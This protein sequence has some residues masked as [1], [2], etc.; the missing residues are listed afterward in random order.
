M[1]SIEWNGAWTEP[2]MRPSSHSRRSRT[3]GTWTPGSAASRAGW[4]TAASRPARRP[5]ASSRPMTRSA[6]PARRPRPGW[7]RIPTVG[8]QR[9][10][11]ALEAPVEGTSALDR[12]VGAGDVPHEA[13][14]SPVR[15]AQGS[16]RR[17]VSTRAK[18]VG[19]G[20]WPGVW[21]A[22]TRR[23]PSA[24]SQPSS[25][26][27]WGYSAPAARCRWSAAPVASASRPWPETWSAR[28]PA[29][30]RARKRSRPAGRDRRRS[31]EGRRAAPAGRTRRSRRTAARAS[32][33]GSERR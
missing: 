11:A 25:K 31:P 23:R 21:I 29:Y 9:Q 7:S 22:R 2:G 4:S 30:F 33:G 18:A 24:S 8:R 32:R 10:Q 6:G 16:S 13:R 5:S 19:S 14:S 12:E 20:R 26:G 28:R 3:S 27:S 17:S 1:P 15:T